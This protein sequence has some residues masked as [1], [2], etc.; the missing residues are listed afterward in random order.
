MSFEFGLYTFGDLTRDPH[1]GRAMSAKQ[2]LDEVV[3][4]AKLAEDVGL[5]VFGLGE[6][7][8]LN[9]SV[10]ATPV[11]LSAIAQYT[12]KIRLTSAT[13]VLSTVDPVRLYED[14][15][16][17]DLLSNGRAEI[18]A[19]RGALVFS[20]T[21][22]LFGYDLADYDDLFDEKI[23]LL[24]KVNENETVTWNGRFRPELVESEVGPRPL[25]GKLPI[26]IGVGRT[27]ASAERA[28]RLGAGLALAQLSGDP[29]RLKP[30]VEAYRAAGKAAG[31]KPEQLPVSISS[32]GYIGRTPR[33]AV[34]EYFP[35]HANYFEH[36]MQK[37]NSA[38]RPS[39][40]EFELA[41]APDNALAV[42]GP[43]QIIE[44]ILLQHELIGHNRYMLQLDIGGVPYAQVA[45]AI[46]LLATEVIPVVRR[47]LNKKAAIV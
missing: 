12:T 42:G 30:L 9:F 16:T 29:I 8:T 31:F 7:H 44:K 10:T 40:E 26:W 17:L 5:D 37:R 35:Y 25:G 32:H 24:L 4:A 43:Q 20:D 45:N 6:H 14:F 22:K 27:L 15:A 33:Q 2:R 21:Y 13:T 46:E 11:V 28:G 36:I 3:A 34:D 23:E 41:T 39:R 19:G 47:E 18:I 1:S 38:D